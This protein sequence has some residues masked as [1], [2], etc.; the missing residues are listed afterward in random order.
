MAA[1]RRSA[2]MTGAAG[3][4]GRTNRTAR[5]AAPSLRGAGL[6]G[7]VAGASGQLVQEITAYLEDAWLGSGTTPENGGSS[8]GEVLLPYGNSAPAACALRALLDLFAAL[9]I[10]VRVLHVRE[11]EITQVGP[12]DRESRDEATACI[13]TAVAQLRCH[14]ITAIGVLRTGYRDR[15]ANL[16]LTEAQASDS[17][18]IVLGARS[19]NTLTSMIVGSTS[20]QVW[21]EATCPVLMVRSS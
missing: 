18:L 20:R 16:I 2:A 13:E 6:D 10:R 1:K 14:G 7:D 5:C 21:R 12:I 15:L 4:L 8:V 19:R 9:P 3:W 11:R 17:S